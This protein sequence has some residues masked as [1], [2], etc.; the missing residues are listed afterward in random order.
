MLYALFFK[1]N[2]NIFYHMKISLNQILFFFLVPFAVF[3]LHIRHEK[4]YQ[5]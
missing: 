3:T 1:N 4:V 5:S 2:M